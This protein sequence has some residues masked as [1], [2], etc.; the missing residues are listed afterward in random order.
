MCVIIQTRN[1][2][3]NIQKFEYLNHR[4]PNCTYQSRSFRYLSLVKK[5][6]R[7]FFLGI[8]LPKE[9]ICTSPAGIPG[10]LHCYASIGGKEEDLTE[11][12]LFLGYQ[13]LVMA[14]RAKTEQLNS[15][16]QQETFTLSFRLPDT[17]HPVA[18]L[19]MRPQGFPLKETGIL[20]FSGISGKHQFASAFHRF[21]RRIHTNLKKEKKGNVHLNHDLYKEV[22]IAY[23][24]PREICLIT[25]GANE[26]F[27]IFPTDLHGRGENGT[28]IISLRHGGKTCAQAEEFGQLALWRM[29]VKSAMLAYSLGKNH[30]HDP[31]AAVQLPLTTA[32][33]PL[34][35][36]PAP[37]DAL[38]CEELELTG[39]AG[40][41]G[42]HRL[43]IFRTKGEALKPDQN[44][45]VHLHRAYVQWHLRKGLPVTITER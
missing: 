28:Y 7:K 39:T 25:L 19:V 44:K 42:V 26:R 31:A 45:L 29:H 40:D 27:N 10:Q 17:L 5:L 9:Y 32:R 21:F 2:D 34:L 3:S 20:L 36:L 6:L 37:A 24:I 11:Q 43:L 13:P 4:N 1:T 30:M 18:K 16:A 35:H 41:F 38:S 14:V 33:S 23:S 8:D 22:K 15:I 12:V